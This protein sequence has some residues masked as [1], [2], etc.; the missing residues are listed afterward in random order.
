[1]FTQFI[2]SLR[3]AGI[4]ASITE[5]LALLGAVQAGVARW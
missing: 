2:L 1:M 4:P 3:H 5:Y